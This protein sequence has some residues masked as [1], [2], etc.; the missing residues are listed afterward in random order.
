MQTQLFGEQLTLATIFSLQSSP[1]AA[2]QQA[3]HA[4]TSAEVMNVIVEIEEKQERILELQKEMGDAV[5]HIA[6]VEGE[7][8]DLEP[9]EGEEVIFYAE[10]PQLEANLEYARV[11]ND[12]EIR[13]LEEEIT[14]LEGELT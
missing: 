12:A 13:E 5:E 6:I 8:L 11:E 7:E 9:N 10:V 14:E 3:M 4:H 2:A 1:T